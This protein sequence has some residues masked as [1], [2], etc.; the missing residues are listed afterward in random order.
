[1]MTV[2]RL[3][4]MM[5]L[6]SLLALAGCGGGGGSAGTSPLIPTTPPGSA[7]PVADL[8]LVLSAP[9]IVNTG[10]TLVTATVTALDANRNALANVAVTLSADNGAVVTVSGTAGSVTDSTGRLQATVGIGSNRSN[11][12]IV[13]TVVTGGITRTANL[14]VVDSTSGTQPTSIEII[15]AATT[16]GT[17]GDGVLIT[18]FVK[19]ANNNAL[20][21]S[22]VAFGAST[23]T[24]SGVSV[25]T[26]A[27]GAATATYAAGADRSNRSATITVSSGT[28]TKTLTLPH[29]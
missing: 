13:V 23:G 1:M 27:L 19:D 17:G 21:A 26:N 11:R 5:G 9:T 7:Q 20:A 3:F 28:V 10:T 8:V 4:S 24:L 6:V 29:R 14:Q 12:Q 2:K 22:P 16:V 15:A 25:V 18:A